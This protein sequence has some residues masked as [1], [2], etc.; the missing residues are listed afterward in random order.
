MN[1]HLKYLRFLWEFS[2]TNPPTYHERV[3][4]AMTNPPS[5]KGP[6]SA[7]YDFNAPSS[8][9]ARPHTCGVRLSRKSR[10]SNADIVLVR[11]EVYRSWQALMLDGIRAM[12]LRGK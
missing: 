6:A 2:A 8:N 12:P 1:F 4:D 11:F 5:D 3:D 10:T 7:Y 9:L